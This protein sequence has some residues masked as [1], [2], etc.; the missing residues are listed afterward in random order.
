MT[1]EDLERAILRLSSQNKL[2]EKP[3]N[4]FHKTTEAD[5]KKLFFNEKVNTPFSSSL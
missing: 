4:I 3:I 1:V 2:Q 5:I